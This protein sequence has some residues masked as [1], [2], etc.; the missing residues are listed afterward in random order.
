M[1]DIPQ[2]F[3]VAVGRQDL[4]PVVPLEDFAL[5]PAEFC[6]GFICRTF[7]YIISILLCSNPVFLFLYSPTVWEI[8]TPSPK[9]VLQHQT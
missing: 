2:T 7:Y 1:G 3:P 4:I 6:P 5:I 9:I 8:S